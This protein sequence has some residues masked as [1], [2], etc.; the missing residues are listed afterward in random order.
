M[1]NPRR[2]RSFFWPIILIGVGAIWLLAN[3]NLITVASLDS[4]VNLW[5]LILIVIGL[6]LLFGHQ[7]PW[8]GAVIG[9]LAI[10][11][12]IA[13]LVFGPALGIAAPSTTQSPQV[14][15]FTTPLDSTSSANMVLNLS[16]ESSDIHA[17]NNSS[18]LFD[19]T[20]GHWG[21]TVIYTVT[22]DQVKSIKL[23]RVTNPANWFR[24]DFSFTSL[25]WDIGVSPDVPVDLTID[26]A[27]G[28]VTADLTGLNLSA[29]QASMASGSSNFTLP[30]SKNAYVAS[31][32]SGS[33]SVH[34]NLPAATTLTLQ[35][36]SASGSVN[37]SLP[38]NAAVRIEVTDSGSGSLNLPSNL[39]S[40]SS[41]GNGVGTWE[42]SNYST[43]ANKILIQVMNRGSGSVNI[44]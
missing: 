14:E 15:T 41:T 7:N 33:G 20:I 27:S 23:S 25:N 18:N 43:A 19:A 42:S 36:D 29:L 44:D 35:L 21:G 12:V 4:L 30:Q 39:Q 13:F 22:G 1:Q 34:A 28:S 32:E 26:G 3:L 38:S 10:G 31:I 8:A 9:L 2:Y 11:A 17:L 5:P 40:I 24:F 16:S 37:I 6:N